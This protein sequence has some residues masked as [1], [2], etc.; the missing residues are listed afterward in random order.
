DLLRAGAGIGV[1]PCFVGDLDPGLERVGEEL[2]E[3]RH[4]QWIVM[5]NDDR[6][7]SDIRVVA[8]RLSKLLKSHRDILAGK[9][10]STSG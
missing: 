10:P 2:P 6:H 7:R 4:R 3:L 1:L 5:N 9:R 8:E